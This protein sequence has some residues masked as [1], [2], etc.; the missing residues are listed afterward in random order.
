MYLLDTNICIALIKGDAAVKDFLQQQDLTQVGIPAV[1]LAELAFGVWKSQQSTRSVAA[2]RE[3]ANTYQIIDFDSV[4]AFHYGQIRAELERLGMMIGPNDFL[5][6]ATALAREATLVTR[7]YREFS[8]VAGL[9]WQ[10][11]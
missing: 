7:N 3:I 8:R 11:V 6:A 2:Y 1:V 4:A 10:T 9:R 5:I